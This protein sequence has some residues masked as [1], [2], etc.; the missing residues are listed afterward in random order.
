MRL[1]DEADAPVA[2]TILRGHR[3]R[4]DLR[5]QLSL[6]RGSGAVMS[7]EPYSGQGLGRRLRSWSRWVHTGEAGGF[8]G[9]TIAGLAAAGATVL[10]WTGWAM[11]WRR[12]FPGKRKTVRSENDARLVREVS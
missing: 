6:E 10:V 7:W 12:F 5:A 11:A 8:I 2:F 1:P 3:G 9:Q 4:P